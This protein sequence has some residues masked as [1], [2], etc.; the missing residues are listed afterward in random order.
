MYGV[1]D[2]ASWKKCYHECLEEIKKRR[3][4][5]QLTIDEKVARAVHQ[6]KEELTKVVDNKVNAAMAASLG[7]LVFAVFE[8]V[9]RNPEA[10]A[11]EF[12]LPALSGAIR[13]TSH[14]HHHLLT[15]PQMLPCLV[16]LRFIAARPPS[17]TCSAGLRLWLSSTPSW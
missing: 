17:L 12:Q 4:H 10:R 6:T 16:S 15:E 8:Y 5:T 13:R 11:E 7:Q 1:G 3:E 2:A 14:H 9:R